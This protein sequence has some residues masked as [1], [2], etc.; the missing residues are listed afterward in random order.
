MLCNQRPLWF[1][2]LSLSLESDSTAT[3]PAWP[4]VKSCF[5]SSALM[6]M[7]ANDAE[8]WPSSARA[9]LHGLHTLLHAP[10]IDAVPL[11][12]RKALSAFSFGS[13]GFL[14]APEMSQQILSCLEE[15]SDTAAF[16][17]SRDTKRAP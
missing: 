7:A 5:L 6:A 1:G 3:A 8:V 17:P 2:G 13:S 15:G 4:L 14:L 16:A 9:R 12:Q 11:D 10:S